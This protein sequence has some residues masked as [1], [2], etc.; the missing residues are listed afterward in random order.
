MKP[1]KYLILNSIPLSLTKIG[2]MFSENGEMAYKCAIFYK[3]LNQM[4]AKEKVA[5]AICQVNLYFKMGSFVKS[6][7][8]NTHEKSKA[9]PPKDLQF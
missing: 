6:V 8:S 2:I 4:M 1:E 9:S 5:S 3:L 7:T